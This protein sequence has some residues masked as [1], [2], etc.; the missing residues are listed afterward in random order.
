[1]I[2]RCYRRLAFVSDPTFRCMTVDWDGRIRMNPSSPYAMQG[3]RDLQDRLDIAFACD[4]DHDRHGIVTALLSAE[5]T[6]CRGR[7]PG[8]LYDALAP[9]RIQATALA[10]D[11]IASILANPPGDGVKDA[12]RTEESSGHE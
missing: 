4:T 12:T 3:L 2:F 11:K 9:Q 5:I 1:M 6:A 8:A 10:G 7:D